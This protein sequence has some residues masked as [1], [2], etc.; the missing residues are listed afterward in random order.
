MIRYVNAKGCRIPKVKNNVSILW[1]GSIPKLLVD[2]KFPIEA[3]EVT[4]EALQ[5]R[6]VAVHNRRVN[7]RRDG[8]QLLL[9]HSL[10]NIGADI[11]Q[12]G[13]S[14]AME[15]HAA[16]CTG[17]RITGL[18]KTQKVASQAASIF[19]GV[20]HYFCSINQMFIGIFAELDEGADSVPIT[21]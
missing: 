15:G 17:G 11:D 9:L 10:L 4:E 5:P 18:W 7:E 1:F 16:V 14:G 20:S 2:S 8:V 3:G 19:N 12:A 6:S 21:L 13:W